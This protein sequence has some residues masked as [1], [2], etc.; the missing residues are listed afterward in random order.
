[1]NSKPIEDKLS[2]EEIVERVKTKN[3][4]QVREMVSQFIA[5]KIFGES[6]ENASQEANQAKEILI[7]EV[8]QIAK[9]NILLTIVASTVDDITEKQLTDIEAKIDQFNEDSGN[10]L[11]KLI[12]FEQTSEALKRTLDEYP[13]RSEIELIIDNKS[14]KQKSDLENTLA[15]KESLNKLKED[16][17]A[18]IDKLEN[19]IDGGN[20]QGGL[21]DKLYKLDKKIDNKFIT[22]DS[23]INS[24]KSSINELVEAIKGTNQQ[25]DKGLIAKVDKLRKWSWFWQVVPSVLV[26][27]VGIVAI[28]YTLQGSY[29]SLSGIISENVKAGFNDK[30]SETNTKIS[31][32]ENELKNL[33]ISQQ[34]LKMN[35]QKILDKLDELSKYSKGQRTKNRG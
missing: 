22:F 30:F 16:L 18:L 20:A 2:P 7:D 12:D 1:M 17:T 19:I 4:E 6:P 13:K 33:Q 32:V 9:E 27:L 8:E 31:N 3:V 29:S 25:S 14:L 23:K 5:K 35:Q 34:E 28:I 26:S 21:V 15:T 11:Q 10:F 24:Q